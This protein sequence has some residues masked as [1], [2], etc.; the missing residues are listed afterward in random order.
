MSAPSIEFE[1][2]VMTALAKHPHGASAP[3][4]ASDTG[5][6]RQSIR[7]VLD[8]LIAAHRV[9]VDDSGWPVRYH[10]TDLGSEWTDWWCSQPK[11]T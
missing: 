2:L 9:E 5:H 1:G 6:P 11:E 10:A 8:R 7:K 3:Q 4:L